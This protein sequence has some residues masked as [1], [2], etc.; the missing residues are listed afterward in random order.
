VVALYYYL[1]VLKAVF[2]SEETC[3]LE[4][5]S[6]GWPSG[7]VILILSAIT[8]GLGVWPGPLIEFIRECLI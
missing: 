3:K 6:I 4:K 7:V 2:V 1:K 8:L 5:D